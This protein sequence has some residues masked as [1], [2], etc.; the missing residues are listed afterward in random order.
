MS[1]DNYIIVSIKWERER[2][3]ERE[4]ERER[5]RAET[6]Y[7]NAYYITCKFKYTL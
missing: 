4:N 6:P 5:E 2:E 3:R 1:N 7:I